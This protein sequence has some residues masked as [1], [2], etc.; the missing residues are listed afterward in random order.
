ITGIFGDGSATRSHLLKQ[1]LSGLSNASIPWVLIGATDNHA[2][3]S[4]VDARSQNVDEAKGQCDLDIQPLLPPPGIALAQFVD[5]L[6]RVLLAVYGLD[7]ASATLLRQALTET[8]QAAGWNG[9]ATGDMI[10]L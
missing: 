8:Y 7:A 1:V 6:L 10:R 9:S 3:A 5:A 2:L 4:T